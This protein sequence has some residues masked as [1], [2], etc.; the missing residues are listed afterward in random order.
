MR[1][2]GLR[3]FS[4]SVLLREEHPASGRTPAT[5]CSRAPLAEAVPMFDVGV[6]RAVSTGCSRR[7]L[8]D[9]RER[10]EFLLSCALLGRSAS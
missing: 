5:V 10:R 2:V 1:E 3:R 7:V 8:G 6:E 9:M 4:G